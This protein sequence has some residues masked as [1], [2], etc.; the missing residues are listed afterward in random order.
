[1]R[2]LK[3][4][5]SIVFLLS[6]P[7]FLSLVL[8]QPEI[9]PEIKAA[10]DKTRSMTHSQLSTWPFALMQPPSHKE[11]MKAMPALQ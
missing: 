11:K 4:I 3:K 5:F 6:A 1:V 2:L 7:A 8:L 10:L 9:F